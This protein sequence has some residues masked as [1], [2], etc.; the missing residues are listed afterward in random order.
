MKLLFLFLNTF[1]LCTTGAFLEL[2]GTTSHVKGPNCFN[3][4]LVAAQVLQYKRF[5]DPDEM[6]IHLSE[7][8]QEIVGS[9]FGALGRIYHEADNLEVH[10][11]LH[12]DESNIFAKHGEN[13]RSGYEVMSYDKMF[14]QY[15]RTKECR[16]SNSFDKH[17]YHKVKYYDC[18]QKAKLPQPIVEINQSIEHLVFS[19][20]TRRQ[21]GYH[22]DGPIQEARLKQYRII[23]KALY[24]YQNLASEEQLDQKL[25][26]ALIKSYVNQLHNIVVQSRQMKCS[27]RKK[28]YEEI[29]K[30]IKLIK[31]M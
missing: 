23:E 22:C 24:R 27:S 19:D 6:Q 8:C 26:E 3:G 20:E 2:D 12:L 13:I 18:F 17:C 30:V 29:K 28:K 25:K 14:K 15:G 16:A 1:F 11:F 4:A 21:K 31:N 9:E 7:N 10:A 5:V